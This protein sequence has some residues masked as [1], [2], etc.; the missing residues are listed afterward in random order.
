MSAILRRA[1]NMSTPQI[2]YLETRDIRIDSIV[3]LY[4]ANEWSSAKKPELLHQALMKSE[5]LISA[6]HGEKL[7]GLGNAISDGALVVYYPH[8]LVLPSYHGLGVGAALMERLKRRYE[9]FHQHMLV[10]ESKAVKFYE[11]M[12]FVRAGTT[13]PMWI[14]SGHDH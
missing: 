7:I 5:T 8:L 13:E 2:T 4:S 14:Y 9:S 6:W 3:E 1:S 12:G 11:K 10:A